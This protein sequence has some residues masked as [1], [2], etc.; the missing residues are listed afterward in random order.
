MCLFKTTC[1]APVEVGCRLPA[2][3]VWVH[4]KF[5]A[6]AWS[7]LRCGVSCYEQGWMRTQAR[8]FLQETL[9]LDMFAGRDSWRFTQDGPVGNC[10]FKTRETDVDPELWL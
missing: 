10:C 3:A 1:S 6:G 8:S 4:L 7:S 5:S 9:R 2:L